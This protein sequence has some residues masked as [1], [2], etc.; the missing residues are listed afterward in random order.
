MTQPADQNTAA[1]RTDPLIQETFRT[2]V[3]TPAFF[4]LAHFDYGVGASFPPAK[5]AGPVAFRVVRGTLEFSAEG[6][7][8]KTSAGSRTAQ[9]IPAGET[10]TVTVD[11]RLVV[12]GDVVHSARTV[13]EGPARILGLALFAGEP[14]QQFPPGITFEPLSLG[15]VTALPATPATASVLRSTIVSGQHWRSG[16]SDGPRIVHVESGTV[17]A[18]LQSGTGTVT[19]AADPLGRSDP[20][21][22]GRPAQ[23]YAG[24]GALLQPGGVLELAGDSA[25]VLDA[26]V[27]SGD[28]TQE[29]DG[30]ALVL[31]YARDMS[32]GAI[33]RLA[34]R[35]FADSYVL[36]DAV[37][38]E[39]V[40]LTGV[41]GLGKAGSTVF[42][43]WS[44]QIDD[45]VAQ[46]DLVA[47]RWALTCVHQGKQVSIPGITI[48]RVREGKMAEGWEAPDVNDLLRQTGAASA[49]GELDADGSGSDDVTVAAGRFIYDLWSAGDLTVV[50]TLFAP[51]YTNHTPLAGQRP[52]RDGVRQFIGR[53]RTAFPDVSVAV[54]L[55]VV[56]RDRAVVRWTSR[57]TQRGG[58]MGIPPSGRYIT[59]SGITILVVRAGVI[60]ESWQQWDIQPL[61]ASG[62]H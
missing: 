35:Y 2:L 42:S 60:V 58:L 62:D 14:A 43:D 56:D 45:Q 49:P 61:L 20:L 4:A 29:A 59:L 55:L 54:D 26:T 25:S 44:A 30:V 52:G 47:T 23:L 36:H 38:G 53:W 18:T 50:D 13:G 1:T 16:G 5:G 6:V 19:R 32:D 34:A 9:D 48:T 15:P 12:P 46:D 41:A 39:A 11:D 10:F 8:T 3:S 31:G 28:S 24:D 21:I 17:T 51:D 22:A 37:W 33:E 57:G 7:V 27:S 40:G